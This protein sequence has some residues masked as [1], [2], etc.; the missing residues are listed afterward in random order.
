MVKVIAKF[1]VKAEG[2]DPFLPLAKELVEITVKEDRNISY[3]M[4]QDTGEPG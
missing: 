2:I 1:S 3:E 4:F